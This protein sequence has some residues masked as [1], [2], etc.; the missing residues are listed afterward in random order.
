MLPGSCLEKVF[1]FIFVHSCRTY[2]K[3]Y[4]QLFILVYVPVENVDLFVF[5]SF[6]GKE[7]KSIFL[8]R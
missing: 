3:H 2:A 6:L 8:F 4:F 1:I 5:I 7:S